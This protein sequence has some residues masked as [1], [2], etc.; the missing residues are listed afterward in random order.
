M[1]ND[2]EH[3]RKIEDGVSFLQLFSCNQKAD[4]RITY[5]TFF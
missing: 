3:T 2:G 1:N 4:S 5:T